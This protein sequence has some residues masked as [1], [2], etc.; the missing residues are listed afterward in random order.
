MNVKKLAAQRIAV[1]FGI[2]L[3]ACAAANPS[4][5]GANDRAGQAYGA[6]LAAEYADS[7]QD[8][9]TAA[10]FY[11]QALQSDPGN[12]I[13]INSGFISALLAGS[14]ASAD[15][16]RQ[17]PGNALA[18]MLL[19]N[20]AAS[21]GQYKTAEALFSQ[22]PDDSLSGLLKPLL[23]AWVLAG[24]GDPNAALNL[25]VPAANNSPFGAV[26]ILNA[27]LIADNAADMKD[28]VQLYAAA[29]SAGQAPQSAAGAD[30]GK[31]EGKARPD[32][33][34]PGGTGTDG[35]DPSKPRPGFASVGSADRQTRH[36]HA[37]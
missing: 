4:A 19:A 5:A 15:L 31:L 25:L 27:A 11:E 1:A 22:L 17:V 35:R 30:H 7:L 36:R 23:L 28:A 14:P 3:S 34:R 6:F 21:Q 13:L 9:A 37:R 12:P 18:T 26:Y 8:P 24:A 20:Q 10:S 29:D 16:A 2:T 33:G 32:A